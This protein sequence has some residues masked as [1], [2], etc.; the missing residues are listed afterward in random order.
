MDNM[1]KEMEN[2]LEN[3]KEMDNPNRKVRWLTA[4]LEGLVFLL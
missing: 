1:E 3:M 4:T 2:Q